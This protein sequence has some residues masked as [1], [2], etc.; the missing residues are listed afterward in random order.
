M[1]AVLWFTYEFINI[2]QITE[3]FTLYHH[4]GVQSKINN[5]SNS[6]VIFNYGDQIWMIKVK[7]VRKHV[8]FNSSFSPC[9]DDLCCVC[10]LWIQKP[11]KTSKTSR[12][13]LTRFSMLWRW[14]LNIVWQHLWKDPFP[15]NNTFMFW[16]Q[17]WQ[18][19]AQILIHIWSHTDMLYIQYIK[20]SCIYCI[21]YF[22]FPL[23]HGL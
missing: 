9:S 17:S 2:T 13:R 18:L 11:V 1:S 6:S 14:R 23:K 3:R 5:K 12:S 4:L 7:F 8:R 22:S 16:N 15:P 19:S 21:F 20:S 10:N